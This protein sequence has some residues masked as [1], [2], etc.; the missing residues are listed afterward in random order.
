MV[1]D[2]SVAVTAPTHGGAPGGTVSPFGVAMI[3]P[4]GNWSL[5]EMPVKKKQL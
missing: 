2:P 3:R 5:N 1:V 4:G